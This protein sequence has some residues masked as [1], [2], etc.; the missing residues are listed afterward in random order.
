MNSTKNSESIQDLVDHLFRHR[1]GQMIA[2]LTRIF[3][4]SHLDLVEDAF[5][6]AIH[7][8]EDLDDHR[9]A[10]HSTLDIDICRNHR[11]I[12]I[13]ADFIQQADDDDILGLDD[14][15]AIES[16]RGEEQVKGFI[17]ADEFILDQGYLGLLQGIRANGNDHL[18]GQVR[19]PFDHVGDLDVLEPER[20]FSIIDIASSLT[21]E[22]SRGSGLAPW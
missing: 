22:T 21:P 17:L 2:S 3:G 16:K 11:Q 6:V 1:A 18:A 9:A 20:D 4:L 7:H 10:I 12:G 5:R 14:P 13:L 19:D 8:R 15:H